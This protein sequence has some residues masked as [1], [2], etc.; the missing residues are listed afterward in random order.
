M[1]YLW[2]LA[3]PLLVAGIRT[4]DANDTAAAYHLA[5]LADATDA[6]SDLHG[7]FS[8]LSLLTGFRSKGLVRRQCAHDL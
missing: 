4:N 1:R 8:R 2:L 3:L 5:V 7:G 6:G